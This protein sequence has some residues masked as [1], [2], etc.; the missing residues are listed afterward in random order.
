MSDDTIIEF[1]TSLAEQGEPQPLPE[2]DYT[3]EIRAAAKK[4]SPNSGLDYIQ[5][6]VFIPAEEYPADFTDGDPDGT[7][8][9]YRRL[10]LEN[11]PNARWRLKRLCEAVG[12]T[13]GGTLDLN[14]F[15]G[16]SIRVRVKHSE[17]EG[18]KRADIVRLL[19]DN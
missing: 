8:L 17:Y 3:G 5:L 14:E 15:I 7:T 19:F 1:Q 10:T 6:D 11:T 4:T 16:R 18:E 12:I 2:R 9:A 13:P